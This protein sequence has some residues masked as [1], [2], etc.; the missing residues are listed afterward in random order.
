M[1]YGERLEDAAVREALEETGIK[2]RMKKVVGVYSDPNRD[3]RGHVISICFL[4]EPSGGALK[5]STDAMRVKTFKKIPWKKL[6][7]DHAKILKDAGFR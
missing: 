4:A 7:F 5:A 2:I 1:E 3:P 6:A